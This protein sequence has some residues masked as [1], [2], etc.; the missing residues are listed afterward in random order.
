MVVGLISY[1]EFL[2]NSECMRVILVVLML[3]GWVKV[4]L[5]VAKLPVK[6]TFQVPVVAIIGVLVV[7]INEFCLFRVN[8]IYLLG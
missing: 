8:M 5:L 2:T 6:Y 7:L 4:V 3:V 1:I